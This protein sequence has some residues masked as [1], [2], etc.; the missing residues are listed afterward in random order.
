VGGETGNVP[1][2]DCDDPSA[3]FHTFDATKGWPTYDENGRLVK[4]GEFTPIAEYGLSSGSPTDGE[5]PAVSQWCA[6]WFDTHPAYHNGGL[7]AMAWYE[8]GVRMLNIKGDGSIEEV[9]WYVPAGG[10]TSGVYWITDRIMY[11]TDYQRSFDIFR[12]TGP[13]PAPTE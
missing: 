11:A 9:G 5:F 8:H 3:R 7:V 4:P 12:Y 1:P 2:G 13:I 10:M 6:H